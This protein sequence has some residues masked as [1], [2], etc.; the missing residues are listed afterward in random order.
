[1]SNLLDIREMLH[2][3]EQTRLE[4]KRILQEREEYIY[5]HYPRIRELDEQS[6][7]SYIK[8]AKARILGETGDTSLNRDL[9]AEKSKLLIEAGY[10]A[11]YLEPIYTCKL[12]KDTGYVGTDKC[13][14]FEEK[15]IHGLYLQSN[16]TDILEK[17]NFSTFDTSFYSKEAFGD[18]SYSPFENITNILDICHR[19]VEGF[20]DK[21]EIGLEDN[22]VKDNLLIYGETGL[23]KT[24]LTNCIAKELLDRQHSVLYLTANE[25]FSDILAPYKINNIYELEPLYNLVYNCELLVIDDL[26]TEFTNEFVRT[27]FFDII[28][29]RHLFKKSTLISTNLSITELSERYSDRITSRMIESYMVF[30]IYGDNIR[31]Q[32][33]RKQINAH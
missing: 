13:K 31:Y 1:M 33:R 14:C 19:F 30:N 28:S 24:F 3:Y 10:P 29:K 18:K 11:D 22:R 21:K 32:K 27:Q 12:C 6:T 2:E 16:L 8:A 20:G 26:G 15:I 9:Q 5:S 7:L 25:L 17:E 23:G 4:N